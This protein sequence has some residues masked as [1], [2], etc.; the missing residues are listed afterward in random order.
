MK[1]FLF[2]IFTVIIGCLIFTGC[3]PGFRYLSEDNTVKIELIEYT[4]DDPHL[5]DFERPEKKPKFDFT[6]A[7]HIATLDDSLQEHFMSEVSKC[8]FRYSD[9]TLN[10]P[11]GK[12]IILYQDNGNIIVLSSWI[13]IGDT[14]TAYGCKCDIFDKDGN[15]IEH[16]GSVGHDYVNFLEGYFNE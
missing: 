8:D 6:K 15:F 10:E 16:R 1:K 2:I 3:D 12:T 11:S 9:Q 7:V 4:N 5:I 14:G 13:Y